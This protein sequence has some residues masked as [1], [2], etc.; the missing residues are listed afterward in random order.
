MKVLKLFFKWISRTVKWIFI[1]LCV[2][3]CSLFFRQQSIPGSWVTEPL[4]EFLPTNLVVSVESV[5]IG[6]RYG[7]SVEGFRLYDRNSTNVFETIMGADYLAVDF[8]R[9]KVTISA[10]KYPRLPDSYIFIII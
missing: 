1:V 2:F 8:L 6:F 10:L 9:R 4:A 3:I 5:M 7:V